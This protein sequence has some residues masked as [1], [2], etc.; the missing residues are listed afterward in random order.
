MKAEQVGQA[1]AQKFLSEGQRIVFWNDP[2][3]EF[4]DYIAQGLPP[5][6]ESVSVLNVTKSGGMSAKLL[7]ER[8]DLTGMY[9]V[10][11]T[12]PR[13]APEV[14]WLL[15]I[16]LYSAEFYADMA[17][18]WLQE[19]GLGRLSLRDHLKSRAAFMGSQERRRKLKRLI[20]RDDDEAALDLK[21]LAVLTGSE[22][23]GLFPII[24]ALCHGHLVGDRFDLNTAPAAVELIDKMGLSECFWQLVGRDFGYAPDEPSVAGLLRRLFVSELFHQMDRTRIDSLAQFELPASGRQNAVVCL[25]QWRDSSGK[26][27]SYD[28]VAMALGHELNLEDLLGDLSLDVLTGVFTFWEA[29]RRVVSQLKS[30][31]IEEALTINVDAVADI[32]TDRKNGHWLTGPGRDRPE[33]RAV[34]NAYAAIVS[35]A[36]LLALRNEHRQGLSFA[37]AGALLAAYQSDLYR[38]DQLYRRFN[39]MAKAAQGQGWDLLKSL[40]EEIERVYDQSFLLPLGLEWSRLLDDGFL[41]SWHLDD[42]PAQQNFYADNVEPRLEKAIHQRAYVIISDA[43]RYEAAQELVAKMNGEY[44]MDAKLTG[45]LGV[46]PSYTALGMASLLPHETLAYSD[47]GKVLVDGKPVEGI[48][49]RDKLLAAVEGM[50]CQAKDLSAMMRK[51]ARAFTEG[52][53]VIYIYHDVIDSRGDT[54]STEDGTFAA[55]GECIDELVELVQL[56]INTLNAG[57]VWV[58]ADHG[59][60]YQQES[61]SDTDKSELAVKP[62]QAFKTKKRYVI[63][64]GLG[65]VKEAHRGYTHVTAGTSCDTEFWVPRGGNLFHFTGGARFVHGGTMPQEVVVPL[66][67]V[68]HVRG[69]GKEST[70]IEKVSVQVLGAQHK[71]TTAKCRFDLIQ[72][73]PVG[74]RRKPLTLRAAVYDGAR[75]VTSVVTLTF[76]STS[77]S[78]DDRKQELMLDLSTGSYDKSKPYR[79]VLRDTDTDAEVLAIPVVIDRSFDNDF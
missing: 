64:P 42:M 33:R 48:A 66:V 77:N 62:A 78:L 1:L 69:K 47:K 30:L 9:L 53:R 52:K 39:T 17:S 23:A 11:S 75:A 35:A 37:D 54:A 38:F 73:D 25:T 21:M 46:L 32:A 76:D 50:A 71:I 31:V 4:T 8:E 34:A 29:E 63:G 79:L 70:R 45:M 19:L 14:D 61:P 72:T 51:E 28:G 7:L 57:T 20:D 68:T 16:R 10:Y 2:H 27:A 74:E 24:R 22:V 40:A 60:L 58:T 26:A 55:V 15:D 56:C 65:M 13:P 18:I 49:T 12:G 36:E 59:F 44:R 41:E 5:E 43:F 3:C 6:L 67:Q